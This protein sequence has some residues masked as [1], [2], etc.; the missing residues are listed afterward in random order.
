M[1]P[2]IHVHLAA[3][4]SNVLGVETLDQ[5]ADVTPIYRLVQPIEVHQGRAPSPKVA[6]TGLTFDNDALRHYESV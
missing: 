2:E 3:A 1:F 6:G 4:L 5:R